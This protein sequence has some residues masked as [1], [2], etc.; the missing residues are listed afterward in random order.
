[1]E[2]RAD[3]FNFFNKINLEGGGQ[4]NG[5]SINNIISSDGVNSNP[6]FGQAQKA[7]GSRTVQ[8]QARFSF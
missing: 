5:G 3:V 2:V 7:L 6:A 1:V 4:D 8:I